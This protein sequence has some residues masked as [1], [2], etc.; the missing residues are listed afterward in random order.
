MLPRIAP[1]IKH[2]D[3]TGFNPL[4]YENQL[5]KLLNEYKQSYT[6]NDPTALDDP[7]ILQLMEDNS[8]AIKILIDKY[9]T[10]IHRQLI[11]KS[12]SISTNSSSTNTNEQIKPKIKRKLSPWQIFLNM[13]PSY[14]PDYHEHPNK[15]ELCKNYYAKLTE[16]QK[17]DICKKYHEEHPDANISI[18]HS[19]KG[20]ARPRGGI[21]GW[22]IF[23][24]EWYTEQRKN[25]NNTGL[26]PQKC[27]EAWNQLTQEERDKYNTIA[28]NLPNSNSNSSN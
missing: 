27:G 20:S 26:Q 18:G 25:P 17:T 6:V 24:K 3:N 22:S 21:S 5:T 8:A 9:I 13:A 12:K 4:D 23:S 10:P 1:I 19:S 11:S 2:N 16:V 14:I 15:M 28:R 7:E